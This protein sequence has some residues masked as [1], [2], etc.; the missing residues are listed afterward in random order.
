MENLFL[1]RAPGQISWWFFLLFL[2]SYFFH[3]VN[4]KNG[5]FWSD[6]PCC[7]CTGCPTNSDFFHFLISQPLF[8]IASIFKKQMKRR[9]RPFR[10]LE[11]NLNKYM[12]SF[13]TV[14]LFRRLKIIEVLN[15]TMIS[16]KWLNQVSWNFQETF[17]WACMNFPENFILI[18]SAV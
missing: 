4:A 2:S 10:I 15:F 5:S 11:K 12:I 6:I 9:Y 3:F 13:H 18:G 1:L 16:P 17:D 14:Q 8:E 7:S